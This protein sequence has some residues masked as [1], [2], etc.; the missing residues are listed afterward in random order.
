MGPNRV[1]YSPVWVI[2][3][4]HFMTVGPMGLLRIRAGSSIATAGHKRVSCRPSSIFGGSLGPYE[5]Q[6]GPDSIPP[7]GPLRK[8]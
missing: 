2:C 7:I 3:W 1:P 6:L 5:S 8:D 4:Y